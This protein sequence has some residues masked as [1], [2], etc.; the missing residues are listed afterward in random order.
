ASTGA[1]GAAVE[2]IDAIRPSFV[3]VRDLADSQ[4]ATLAEIAAGVGRTADLVAS[5][6]GEADAV[7]NATVGLDRQAVA[8]EEAA[9]LSN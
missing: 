1:I 7:R 3:L 8:V 2:A 4:A 6:H 9:A 5:V